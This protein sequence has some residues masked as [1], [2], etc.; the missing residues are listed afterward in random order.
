MEAGALPE[1]MLLWNTC[2]KTN[3]QL[4]KSVTDYGVTNQPLVDCGRKLEE[5]YSKSTQKGLITKPRDR[6]AVCQRFI[7]SRNY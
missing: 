4:I 1:E 6:I 3:V 2:T 7:W 5:T